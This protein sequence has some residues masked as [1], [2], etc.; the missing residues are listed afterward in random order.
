VEQT[1]TGAAPGSP[2]VTTHDDAVAHPGQ[3]QYIRVAV[4]LALVTAVEVGLYYTDLDGLSLVSLL[5]G[6]AAVKFGMVAAYFMHL[7]FDGRLL[8]RMFV[9]GIVLACGVYFVAL[10][11]LDVLVG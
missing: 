2:S 11:T 1:L 9:T 3:A 10:I 4:I 5:A 8:R 7:R 6:L